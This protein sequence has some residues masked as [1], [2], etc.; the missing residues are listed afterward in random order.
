MSENVTENPAEREEEAAL[1]SLAPSSVVRAAAGLQAFAGVLTTL[2]GIQIVTSVRFANAIVGAV[3][4]A[5][6]ALGIATVLVATMVYRTRGWAAVAGAWLSTAAT[7][8][9]G[10]WVVFA[11]SSGMLSPLSLLVPPV[12]F[13]GALT[14]FLAIGPCA[15]ASAARRKLQDGGIEL[16]F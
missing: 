1:R 8:G 7:L 2:V 10:M 13:A 12:G 15:R 6:L 4:W 14:G 9:I 3:P 16:G 5:M 11:L